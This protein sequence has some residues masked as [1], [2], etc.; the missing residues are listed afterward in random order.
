MGLDIPR[1]IHILHH[2]DSPR[3][4]PWTLLAPVSPVDRPR[5][6]W[7]WWNRRYYR[8]VGLHA[9]RMLIGRGDPQI[10]SSNDNPPGRHFDNTDN[11]SWTWVA[12]EISNSWV[13]YYECY[14]KFNSNNS[15]IIPR[16]DVT[17]GFCLLGIFAGLSWIVC[18]RFLRYFDLFYILIKTLTRAVPKCLQ[19][20]VGV[21][22]VLIGYPLIGSC[23][24]YHS[25][26]FETIP[27][28]FATLFSLMNGDIVPAS[29]GLHLNR[30]VPVPQLIQGTEFG[31]ESCKRTR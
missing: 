3:L 5:C 10:A 9:K 13:V 24:F 12:E 20:V 16:G 8:P 22:P 6:V 18:L 14:N 28:S 23:L 7:L 21:S 27:R 30:V 25:P 17:T 26:F 4:L 31:V 19:F 2:G 15:I 1:H 11:E 29:R